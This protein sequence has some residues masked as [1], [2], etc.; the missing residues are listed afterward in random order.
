ML[1]E[2]ARMVLYLKVT[3]DKYELPLAVAT[4]AEELARMTGANANTIR[5]AVCHYEKGRVKNSVYKR[6]RIEDEEEQ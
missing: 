4:S 1:K 2:G 3:N 5:A 6:V